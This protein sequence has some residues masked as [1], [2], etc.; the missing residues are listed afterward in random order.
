MDV[1]RNPPLY[2]LSEQHYLFMGCLY[3]NL[4]LCD[5]A[6]THIDL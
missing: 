5:K 3:R 6:L 4:C 1:F 2:L